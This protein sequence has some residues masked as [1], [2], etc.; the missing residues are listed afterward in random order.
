MADLYTSAGVNYD[1]L[2]PFKRACQ[3]AA[4]RTTGV[5]RTHGFT[6][7]A[8]IRGESCYLIEAPE[9]FYAHVEEALGTKI[10]VADAMYALTGQSFYAN[11]AI[12]DVATI[13]NDLCSC[14]ALPVTVAMYAAVGDSNYF[15]DL[16]RGA[17]LADG[18]A[19]GCRRSGAAWG[20]GETQ[21]LP[22]MISP[23]TCVLGGSAFGR[24]APKSLR[25]QGDVQDGDAIIFLA[26]SGIQTNGLSLCRKLA[27]Q[28][29]QGYLTPIADGRTY[30]EALL[31]PSVIYVQYVAACQAAGLRLHYAAHM[32]GHGWRKIMRL[33]AP[34]VYRINELRPHPP[35]FDAIVA[36]AAMSTE[37][38]YGTFNMGVGFAVYVAEADVDQALALAERTGYTAWRAGRVTT[39]GDSKAVEILP[40]GITYGGESLQIR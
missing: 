31:D 17:D 1:I 23:G 18:F 6:E 22:G 26:S 34:F 28:M 24:I 27:E 38:A 20:G 29:P 7:P 33:D 30:G 39:E 21:A 25:I 12:D 37:E 15:A 4:A 11:V 35:V 3:Q 19:E 10:L 9:A 16:R 2:D 13:T 8:A 5:L 32:T 40:L 14:G 36:T